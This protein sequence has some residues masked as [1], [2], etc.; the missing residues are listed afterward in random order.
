MTRIDRFNKLMEAR[1]W[2]NPICHVQVKTDEKHPPDNN[3]FMALSDWDESV[4]ERCRKEM[5]I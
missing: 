2:D 3:R 5:G 4:Y 1:Q